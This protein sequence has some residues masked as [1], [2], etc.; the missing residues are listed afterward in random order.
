MRTCFQHAGAVRVLEGAAFLLLSVTL[1]GCLSTPTAKRTTP[2][3]KTNNTSTA[4][5]TNTQQ[6]N[7]TQNANQTGGPAQNSVP[8]V[9]GSTGADRT[10]GAIADPSNKIGMTTGAVSPNA[11]NGPLQFNTANSK[12]TATGNPGSVIAT[13][14]NKSGI[15]PVSVTGIQPLD[16]T[17]GA[18]DSTSRSPTPP[19]VSM[20]NSDPTGRSPTQR[21][22]PPSMDGPVDSSIQP[23]GAA[24]RQ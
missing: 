17:P 11:N 3:Q 5:S 21:G 20:Q 1:C 19:P 9:P 22:L 24:T 12:P 18:S 6:G 2:A 14:N 23:V 16:P 8:A 15:Q 13:S 7:I 10:I 4:G